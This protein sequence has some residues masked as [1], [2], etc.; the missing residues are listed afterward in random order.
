MM[1]FLECKSNN[2]H[3][4]SADTNSVKESSEIKAENNLE[5]NTNKINNDAMSDRN[6]RI[7]GA[8]GDPNISGDGAIS[9]P[10]IHSDDS[11]NN[12]NV[13]SDSAISGPI[14]HNDG[15]ICDPSIRNDG[16]INSS[17][18]I[19]FSTMSSEATGTWRPDV[20]PIRYEDRSGRWQLEPLHV[21]S[22]DLPLVDA[23][24]ALG[25]I[26]SIAEHRGM[27]SSIGGD[28]EWVNPALLAIFTRCLALIFSTDTPFMSNIMFVR[29]DG[30]NVRWLGSTYV[31]S[32]TGWTKDLQKHITAIMNREK[33]GY[34]QKALEYFNPPRKLTIL[35]P[36]LRAMWSVD[37]SR[38]S[39]A[40]WRRTSH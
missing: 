14:I 28:S 15:A 16:A 35:E 24:N 40:V 3:K 39:R 23:P 29:I 33:R 8:I 32:V 1:I 37:S 36:V 27:R 7:D 12:S 19:S 26:F 34:V 10:K 13:P 25:Y 11:I 38:S 2:L 18:D 20:R 17:S 4:N 21:G 5:N 31:T 9:D 6:I 30:K 22:F